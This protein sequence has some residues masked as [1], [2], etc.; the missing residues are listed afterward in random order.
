MEASVVLMGYE[1]TNPTLAEA[2]T[3]AP[4]SPPLRARRMQR[5]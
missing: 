3:I 5:A 1:K 4:P 2:G